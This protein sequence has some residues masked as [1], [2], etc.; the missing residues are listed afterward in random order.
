MID[1]L[2]PY[3]EAV[4]ATQKLLADRKLACLATTVKRTIACRIADRVYGVGS[5][6]EPRPHHERE[7]VLHI[8]KM[9]AEGEL[10]ERMDGK[11]LY[12][13]IPTQEN[14]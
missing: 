13:R 14:Q 5:K 6:A 7:A 11:R 9:L 1:C 10:E 8:R 12:Y 2:I 4:E 3:S